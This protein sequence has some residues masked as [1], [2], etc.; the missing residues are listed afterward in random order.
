MANCSLL[1][2]QNTG[3]IS[4]WD[5]YVNGSTM[6][7]VHAP[8]SDP[9][10]LAHVLRFLNCMDPPLSTMFPYSALR[11]SMGQAWIASSTNCDMHVKV[12]KE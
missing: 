3:R 9:S 2:G 11:T 1:R 6:P 8:L 4:T 7:A 5:K 12:W 10:T